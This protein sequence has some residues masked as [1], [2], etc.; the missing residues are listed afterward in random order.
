MQQNEGGPVVQQPPD[1]GQQPDMR[2]LHQYLP[3]DQHRQDMVMDYH[4]T[5]PQTMQP[6]FENYDPSMY[7]PVQ[8]NIQPIPHAAYGTTYYPTNAAFPYDPYHPPNQPQLLQPAHK[9]NRRPRKK[10]KHPHLNQ[11]SQAGSGMGASHPPDRKSPNKQRRGPS[12]NPGIARGPHQSPTSTETIQKQRNPINK[13]YNTAASPPRPTFTPQTFPTL[14]A[15]E[16]VISRK[17]SGKSDADR[18]N[19][20][21][22]GSNGSDENGA[23]RSGGRSGGKGKKVVYKPW[24]GR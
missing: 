13:G 20:N 8:Q 22:S 14:G 23:R 6:P 18:L 2:F 4:G 10:N 3:P 24:D 12:G 16:E 11:D 17:T 15:P 19:G 5:E 1:F 7:M 9:R 21:M